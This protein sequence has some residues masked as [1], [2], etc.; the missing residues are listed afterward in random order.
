MDTV[1]SL[2]LPPDLLKAVRHRARREHLDESTAM[3]QLMAMGAVEYAVRLYRSGALTL[4][5][6]AE[7]AGLTARE[8]LQ[9]LMDRGAAGNVTLVQQRR[10]LEHALSG[11]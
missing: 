9:T 10:A 8:M 11:K 3:R 1:K 5:Q 4:N 6:A 7:V 2:R